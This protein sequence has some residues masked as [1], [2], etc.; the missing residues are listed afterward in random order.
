[1]HNKQNIRRTRVKTRNPC[2][3]IHRSPRLFSQREYNGVWDCK[4][5]FRSCGAN[6][7]RSEFMAALSLYRPCWARLPWR[8]PPRGGRGWGVHAGISLDY[9]NFGTWIFSRGPSQ[10]FSAKRI[11]HSGRARR[12]SKTLGNEDDDVVRGRGEKL[13]KLIPCATLAC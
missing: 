8:Q 3:V 13:L 6:G 4:Y 10:A 11:T 7:G 2:P 9:M 5:L 1:M 12:L